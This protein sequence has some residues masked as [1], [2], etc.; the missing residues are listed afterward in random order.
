VELAES[1]YAMYEEAYRQGAADY[2]S[3]RNAGD[4][5]LQAQYQVQQ[6]YYNFIAA[7]LDME[8]ELNIP[9]TF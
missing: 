9:F 5:L 1:A 2:Q 4:S 6:E 3:L 7:A 8:K